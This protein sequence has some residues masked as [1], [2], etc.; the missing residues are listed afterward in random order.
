MAFLLKAGERMNSGSGAGIR[1]ALALLVATG[2]A[3]GRAE[4]PIQADTSLGTGNSV[5]VKGIKD[6]KTT[7]TIT[8]GAARN[9]GRY[10]FHSFGKFNVPTNE[11]ALFDNGA[12]VLSIFSRVSGLSASMIDGLIKANHSADLYL[13]NPKGIV[14]GPNARIDVGGAFVASTAKALTFGPGLEFSAAGGDAPLLTSDITPGLQFGNTPAV[15]RNEGVLVAKEG[16]ELLLLGGP[17]DTVTSTGELTTNGGRVSIGGGSTTVG[18]SSGE[19]KVTANGGLITLRGWGTRSSSDILGGFSLVISDLEAAGGVSDIGGDH[20]ILVDS[21]VLST[22]GRITIYSNSTTKPVT[23]HSAT[24][25]AGVG[26][27]IYITSRKAASIESSDLWVDSG[28]LDV[29]GFGSTNILSSKL[30]N[31]GGTI[32]IYGENDSSI[33]GS[34]IQALN[35]GSGTALKAGSITVVEG[36]N[37]SI[38]SDHGRTTLL[39]G[40]APS[41]T[42][43]EATAANLTLLDGGSPTNGG[44][45]SVKSA[46]HK[47]IQIFSGTSATPGLTTLRGATTITDAGRY[48]PLGN[49]RI[50]VG[51]TSTTHPT[52]KI[53]TV[54]RG[55]TLSTGSGNVSIDSRDGTSIESAT[56]SGRTIDIKGSGK[57][58]EI[59]SAALK[60]DDLPGLFTDST[61]NIVSNAPIYIG[62]TN[63][64]FNRSIGRANIWSNQSIHLE[65]SSIE[66]AF[67]SVSINSA[68]N[69]AS[70]KSTSVLASNIDISGGQKTA[71]TGTTLTARHD[72]I[73]FGSFPPIMHPIGIRVGGGIFLDSTISPN[74]SSTT[75]DS[76]SRLQADGRSIF[77][78]SQH[79]GSISGAHIQAINTG[80]GSLLQ[81][82]SIFIQGGDISIGSDHGRTTLLAGDAPSLTGSEATAANL[83]LLDGGSRNFG[84]S[85]WVKGGDNKTIQIFSGTS[86]TPGLT[87]LRG[88]TRAIAN[89]SSG[90]SSPGRILVG[91]SLATGDDVALSASTL[92]SG[93]ALNADGSI[94]LNTTQQLNIHTGST[95]TANTINLRAPSADTIT[96]SSL[97]NLMGSTHWR[98]SDIANVAI[99]DYTPTANRRLSIEAPSIQAS[100]FQMRSGVTWQMDNGLAINLLATGPGGLSLNNTSLILER[101]GTASSANAI[102]QAKATN[103]DLSLNSGS[104]QSNTSSDVGG[105]LNL[106]GNNIS[107]DINSSLT[108]KTSG[109]G[110][111]GNIT[112]FPPPDSSDSALK[113]KGPGT[114]QTQASGSGDAG[115]IIIG[116]IANKDKITILA[117]TTNLT[118]G[119]TLKAE[120]GG[121]IDVASKL[122]STL[123]K[124]TS[125]E[126][127]A[128]T[129]SLSGE[130]I[131]LEG[132]YGKLS[133]E[134]VNLN[135]PNLRID[136]EFLNG[137][138]GDG[139][140]VFGN[141]GSI[142]QQSVEFDIKS[143]I[144]AEILKN[145]IF[146]YE[147][148]KISISK[149]SLAAG[150]WVTNQPKAILKLKA[151]GAEGIDINQT[152]INFS[153]V[154]G[155]SIEEA[156]GEAGLISLIAENG[157]IRIKKSEL[158][159]DGPSGSIILKS[160]DRIEL[161]NSELS[162]IWKDSTNN[163]SAKIPTPETL[164]AGNIT[165]GAN[166]INLFNSKVTATTEGTV[167]GGDITVNTD[168][169]ILKGNSQLT[170]SS[171]KKGE[172]G[173]IQINADTPRDLSIAFE[174][175]TDTNPIIANDTGDGPRITAETSYKDGVVDREAMGGSITIGTPNKTLIISGPGTIS[176]ETAGSGR[177]GDI[178]LLGDTISL[179]SA[180]NQSSTDVSSSNSQ[181]ANSSN[182][183]NRLTITT[184]TSVPQ[185]KT[186]DQDIN[187][188]KSGNG[189]MIR[190]NADSLILKGNSHLTASS[191]SKGE[192]GKI[193]INADTPRD[194]SIA[195]EKSTDTNPIIANGTG[196]G[197]R[198]TAESSYGGGV[199]DRE[200]MGGSITIG[201]PNKNLTISGPGTISAETTGSGRG[202]DIKL[203]GTS[204]NLGKDPQ[205]LAQASKTSITA[206]TSGTGKG[207]EIKA[208]AETISLN[209]NTSLTTQ[210]LGAGE[211]G[212][213]D[214]ITGNLSL[215]GGSK[216]STQTSGVGR[217]G[218]IFINQDSSKPRPLQINFS[219][220]SEINALTNQQVSGGGDGGNISIGTIH[221]PLSVSG[222]GAITAET[223][224]TGKGG[225][226]AL[227]G[228]SLVLGQG[229]TISTKTSHTEANA[230]S[231]GS[232]SVQTSSLEFNGAEITTE[233]T[234]TGQAGE[235]DI[236]PYGDGPFVMRFKNND[237]LTAAAGASGGRGGSIR[238]DAGSRDVHISGLGLVTVQSDGRGHAGDI[239]LRGRS[240]TLD[241]HTT[242]SAQTRG[243]GRGGLINLHADSITLN[244]GSRVT[245]SS[246]GTTNEATGPAGAITITA[247]G[248]NSLHLSHGSEIDSFTSSTIPFTDER[249]L[250]NITINT[251]RLTL[252]D[253]SR[254][255][256][257]TTGAARGGSIIL[258]TPLIS[259]TQGTSITTAT[260]GS[261]GGGQI[262]LDNPS[263]TLTLSGPGSL[264]AATSERGKGGDIRVNS[265]R[266]TLEQGVTLSAAT[267]GA[268][269]GGTISV[270][271]TQGLS[272]SGGA[273][274][275]TRSSAGTGRAGDIAIQTDQLALSDRAA[276]LADGRDNGQA[277]NIRITIAKDLR[278]TNQS[279]INASTARSGASDKDNAN[280]SLKIGGNLVITDGSRINAS[281]MGSANGGNLFLDLSDGFLLSSFPSK[282]LGNDILASAEFGMGGNIFVRSLGI[283]GMNL[284]TFQTP[285]SEV[286][287][288]SIAGRNGVVSIHNPYLNPDRGLI[289]I[290]QPID[291]SND[292]VRTCTPR[293][294][295]RRAEFTQ[296]GRGGLPLQPGEIPSAS[297]LLDDLGRPAPTSAPITTSSKG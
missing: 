70:V 148:A 37:V 123:S 125:I 273:T 79:S 154:S 206:A 95:L 217:G 257:M 159:A 87:T 68:S 250:A 200:A 286:S 241:Q 5:V 82:G 4:E 216:L 226:V 218:M 56:I 295:G 83:T 43:S 187:S 188:F 14:F 18:G 162:A 290:E 269:A 90:S 48:S 213:I 130:K 228:Q 51:G 41:L 277:G 71:I 118:N 181:L 282:F 209:N 156:S 61:I 29:Y 186:G 195:F 235:L 24:V 155:Q 244:N 38:G 232:V 222:L 259:L 119:I 142:S 185:T 221:S 17:A 189:G 139:I 31:N 11:T 107:L 190:V 134:R 114:I 116:G 164:K 247:K 229:A 27:E 194:L 23:I 133:S 238:I 169:L 100:S 265:R 268:A 283:F 28:R 258:N 172:A 153:N 85:I 78:N 230:G 63:F 167:R 86:A 101:T 197:P 242:I 44:S 35:K 285:I 215:G 67:G 203:M 49:G 66:A 39:A 45:I 128:G 96:S 261:G 138:T 166:E 177:G 58:I 160:N 104:I 47:T 183:N 25:K 93:V 297:P 207:G 99:S 205:N 75:I 9:S 163:L 219:D 176:A 53:T 287:A 170:A 161:E 253:G 34:A 198:I 7:Y 3:A 243:S 267:T 2:A 281:A 199:V 122:E 292:V 110:K 248:P 72:W 129:I 251:P 124:D 174:K 19:A 76:G 140:K 89:S 98:L 289:P 239:T 40:D 55:T 296:S 20:S 196:D 22:N 234:G 225:M 220:K 184:M 15:L 165:L 46:N 36:G 131:E 145:R 52:S 262:R 115:Q 233:S 106:I 168:S 255:N 278:L 201:T 236:Q 121:T 271:S 6:G 92:G 293:G 158:L 149:F 109:S 103:G 212:I 264:T 256:A 12:A 94:N 57:G 175:S 260:S 111:G 64:N 252:S 16:K 50:L 245:T 179:D 208:L 279:S 30:T 112:L 102:F 266:G 74:S 84:G 231:G 10:L 157:P 32:E 254:I 214:F 270:N 274:I 120:K 88:A 54:G 182:A 80:F 8:G 249:D 127:T 275:S 223:Q 135:Q 132:G 180:P 65:S 210:T 97:S 240:L 69:E 73:T 288:K 178:T 1:T 108:S 171:S 33:T 59:N 81:K 117:S 136:D 62:S 42:G 147:A 276:I 77:I 192:A 151:T 246:N 21:A 272:L 191:S 150:K 143:S 284:N 144:G 60:D 105:D 193:Q 211:G 91:G 294:D 146:D 173:K 113:V 204:I 224:G 137:I 202:G 291:A 280:I 26:G 227:K 126:A 13:I 237:R 263:S 152:N 141:A